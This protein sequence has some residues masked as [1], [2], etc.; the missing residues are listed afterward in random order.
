MSK[1]IARDKNQIKKLRAKI[2]KS[3]AKGKLAPVDIDK[4]NNKINKLNIKI[5]K[6]QEKFKSYKEII[7]A[8]RPM[9]VYHFS[10]F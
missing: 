2:E 9:V 6:N 4:I 7:P 1:D 10:F 8:F 3:K 5:A